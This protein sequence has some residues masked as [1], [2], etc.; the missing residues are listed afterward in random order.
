MGRRAFSLIEL[1]IVLG[2][3]L[4][5]SGLGIANYQIAAVRA[6]LSRVKSDFRSL[7]AAIEAYTNDHNAVPRMAHSRFYNDLTLD[8]FGQWPL[9]GNLSV[10]LTTPITYISNIRYYDP[11]MIYASKASMDERL[12]TYQDLDAYRQK[13]SKSEFWKKAKEFYGGWRLASV[14]P[15]GKF[16]H[17][18]AN[19]GQ[20]PYD[21]TNGIVS[22]GNLWY[23]P[24]A[25]FDAMPPIPDLLG[26]H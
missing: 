20:L 5:L 16:D 23:S 26:T 21:S 18:F 8:Y 25:S 10:V 3:L 19:S 24:K 9:S 11:F 1:L 7:A 14:G 17:G 4:I 12:Y 15:D 13:N 6:K 2:I 22:A